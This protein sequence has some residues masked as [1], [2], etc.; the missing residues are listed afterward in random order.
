MITLHIIK[1]GGETIND[2]SLL[3]TFL[4]EIAQIR[5]PKIL[6]HGGGLLA[7]TLAN[8][9]GIEQQLVDGRRV[10][11]VETLKI[12]CMVYAG[13]INKQ[14]VSTCQSFGMNAIGL[15]G[16]DLNS[17][18]A[19]IRVK[20]I[21]DF[22]YAGDLDENSVNVPA[23]HSLLNMG[24]CPVVCAITHDGKGQLLNT[25]ADTIA[26]YLAMALGDF[27][28]VQLN[29]CFEK[30]GVLRNL[31]DSSSVI[32]ILTHNEYQELKKTG[33]VN[34]GMIPKLDN[35]FKTLKNGV[36]VVRIGQSIDIHRMLTKQ[37]FNGTQLSY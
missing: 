23:F 9:L 8:K 13:L 20:G 36:Q 30:K 24:V 12:A 28:S 7:T 19:K 10:T 18:R 4:K 21:L 2:E 1:I 34:K 32:G 5:T 11:N 15:S 37:H 26:A 27:H 22:G 3:N 6:I 16:A 31:D 17:I 33:L 35:A 14:I 25:N 29:Y